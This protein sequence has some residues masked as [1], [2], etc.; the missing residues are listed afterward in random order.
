MCAAPRS[1]A[2]L[3]HTLCVPCTQE[4]KRE[5]DVEELKANTQSKHMDAMLELLRRERPEEEEEEEGQEEE[6]GKGV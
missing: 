6:E 1:I 2:A 4:R 5:L 3:P